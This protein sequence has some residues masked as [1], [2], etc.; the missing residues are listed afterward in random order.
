MAGSITR[1]KPDLVLGCRSFA[2][3]R[4]A[5]SASSIIGAEPT[6]TNQSQHEPT[7]ANREIHASTMISRQKQHLSTSRQQK[8][9][10]LLCSNEGSVP[11]K[12]HICTKQ[13]VLEHKGVCHRWASNELQIPLAN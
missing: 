2:M 9:T 10:L 6:K 12:Q 1:T 7:R 4:S 5:D 13:R 3:V 11:P 8:P